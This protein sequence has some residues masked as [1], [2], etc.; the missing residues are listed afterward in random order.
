MKLDKK[1]LDGLGQRLNLGGKA[2]RCPLCHEFMVK[3]WEPNRGFF[4][5]ACDT[6]GSCGIA[7]RVDDPF[8]NKWEQALEKAG[9]V[10]CP[11]PTCERPMRYFATQAGFVKTFCPK[12]KA[13]VD[14]SEPDRDK[15]STAYTPENPGTMQ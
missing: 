8:I 6:P 5:F 12:C 3:K 1:T 10:L 9:G 14:N 2:P 13:T 4:I 15:E 11:R 7:C